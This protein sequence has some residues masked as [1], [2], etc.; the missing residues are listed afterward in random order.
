ML[1][2]PKLVSITKQHF[3]ATA[4]RNDQYTIHCFVKWKLWNSHLFSATN[5]GFFFAFVPWSVHY[6]FLC[7]IYSC[8]KW[9]LSKCTYGQCFAFNSEVLGIAISVIKKIDPYNRARPYHL[10]ED[11]Q[12]FD[13]MQY[14]R[15]FLIGVPLFTGL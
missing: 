4:Q 7:T 8:T 2:L 11:F 1:L 14:I 9:Q 3:I 12:E 6:L 15:F 10:G 13:K 5:V